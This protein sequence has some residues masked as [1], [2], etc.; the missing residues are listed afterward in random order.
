M[1]ETWDTHFPRS[2]SPLADEPWLCARSEDSVVMEAFLRA[3]LL[4]RPDA[5]AQ[6]MQQI[7]GEWLARKKKREVC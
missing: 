5:P 6:K 3:N 4:V 2:F 7:A 1:S